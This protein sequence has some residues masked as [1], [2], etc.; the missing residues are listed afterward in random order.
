MDLAMSSDEQR[1]LSVL[2]VDDEAAMREVLAIRLGEWGFD[3]EVAADAGEARD[4][5]AAR[6][7]AVVISDVVLPEASGLELLE[8]LRAGDPRRPVI[9]VTA[10]GTVDTAVEAMKRGAR[11]FLTKPLDYTKLRAVLDDARDLLNKR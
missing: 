2:V 5:A 6:D 11:D 10:Y 9:L 4:K 3:V 1:P 8:M 7:P